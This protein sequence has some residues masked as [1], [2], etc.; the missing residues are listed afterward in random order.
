[1]IKKFIAK[2]KKGFETENNDEKLEI[3]YENLLKSNK[4][5][6]LING[7]STHPHRYALKQACE[8][9]GISSPIFASAIH[10][11]VLSFY[12]FHKKAISPLRS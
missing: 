9:L 11:H 4:F 1:M 3:E 6:F 2:G 8:I 7:G 12:A 10:S 5:Y